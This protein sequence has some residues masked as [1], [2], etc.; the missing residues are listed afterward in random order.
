M[1]P[2]AQEVLDALT[3]GAL[4]VES[5]T[6]RYANPILLEWVGSTRLEGQ[7]LGTALR[8]PART[9]CLLCQGKT[10]QCLPVH[11][12]TILTAHGEEIQ[13]KVKH[14]QLPSGQNLLVLDL[15][16]EDAAL[17]QAHTDFVSTVSHEFRTPLT[18]IKGFAD[19]LL[20][21]GGKLSEEQQR[22]FISIIKDQADRLIRL[23]ENLL[24]V[25]RI[26]AGRLEMSYRPVPLLK[27]VD[28]VVQ[29][30]KIKGV[31][32]REFEIEMNP[33][34]PPVWADA[35]RLEQVLLNLVDNAAKYSHPGSTIKVAGRLAPDAEDQ[36]CI[37]VVDQGIGIPPEHL[38]EIFTK[39][40]RIDS[41]LTQQVE[42]TGLG[43]YIVRSLTQAMGGDITV[44]STPERG[45]AFTLRFQAAT[46]ELQAAHRRK[47]YAEDTGS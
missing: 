29:S 42:G 12:A 23:V 34:L 39:F 28:K 2:S 37:D 26:G 40:Y 16:S 7:P 30:I 38:E 21:Y 1:L 44:E 36:V 20:Q 27:L 22:R 45:T 43:L 46:A 15:F 32:D 35:D 3:S 17:T 8:I 33:S 31:G 41:P 18:S 10:A 19:T 13:V 9:N 4:V 24:S 25:S 14:S 5:G 47:L 6:I 11:T